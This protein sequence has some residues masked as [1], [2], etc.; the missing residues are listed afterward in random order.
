MPR[1]SPIF[2]S[3]MVVKTEIEG[4]HRLNLSGAHKEEQS[5]TFQL[6]RH[7]LTVP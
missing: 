6:E 4:N 3:P 1:G 2:R 7:M 5:R